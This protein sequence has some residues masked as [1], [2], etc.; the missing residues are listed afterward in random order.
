MG[1]TGR[2]LQPKNKSDTF[3]SASEE[4]AGGVEIA[5]WGALLQVVLGVFQR[6]HRERGNRGHGPLLQVVLYVFQRKH[7]ERGNRGHGPLLQVVLGVFQRKHLR[8]GIAKLGVELHFPSN[9][10]STSILISGESGRAIAIVRRVFGADR[11]RRC[12]E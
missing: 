11:M 10:G 2:S 7:R 8:C 1:S 5:R 9:F 6:K 3:S 4:T 12:I